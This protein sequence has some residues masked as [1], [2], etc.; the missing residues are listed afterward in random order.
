MENILL[1]L[2]CCANVWKLEWLWHHRRSH[3][4]WKFL[5]IIKFVESLN[6]PKTELSARCIQK[7]FTSPTYNYT[8]L[9]EC[10]KITLHT[11]PSL[12]YFLLNK[13]CG[14]SWWLLSN[15]FWR[16]TVFGRLKLHIPRKN[17]ICHLIQWSHKF[18]AC[19][20]QVLRNIVSFW[21]CWCIFY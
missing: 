11:V 3:F 20:D 8:F 9:F 5:F 2:M 7:W 14:F 17:S 1:F 4:G 18:F 10:V 19:S 6:R 21:I 16:K 13:S 12:I 15:H